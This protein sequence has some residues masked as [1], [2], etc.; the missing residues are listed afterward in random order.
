MVNFFLEANHILT[1]NQW[2]FRKVKATQ[3]GLLETVL[4]GL[5][6]GKLV[7]VLYVDLKKLLILYRMI[8][9]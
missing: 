9:C 1:N 6:E 3:D 7:G 8:Y 2:G 5:N 4:F